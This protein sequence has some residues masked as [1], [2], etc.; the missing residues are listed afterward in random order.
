VRGCAGVLVV[1]DADPVE[2]VG[3]DEG[4]E[5]GGEGHTITPGWSRCA[6]NRRRSARRSALCAACVATGTHITTLP[7]TGAHAGKCCTAT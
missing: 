1:T 4:T 7:S 6:Y 2:R 5:A 3:L